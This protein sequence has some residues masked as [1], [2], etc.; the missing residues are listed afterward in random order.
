MLRLVSVI[1]GVFVLG[2]QAESPLD[3]HDF[4]SFQ[5]TRSRAFL[6]QRIT[7]ILQ[8]DPEIA[9]YFEFS[10]SELSIF[11]SPADKASRN[12][13]YQITFGDLPLPE[14]K[15][16]APTTELP[17]LGARIAIDPGHFGGAMAR[18]L[19]ARYIDMKDK[20][21]VEFDEGTLTL[22][23]ALLLE[24]RFKEKGASVLLTRE[25]LEEGGLKESFTKWRSSSA[26]DEAVEAK[27]LG[28]ADP[29]KR[30]AAQKWWKEEATD[31]EVF[32]M[33]YSSLDFVA[34]AEKI[35][36]FDPHLTL[37]IHFNA[38]G[39]REKESGKNIASS[40]NYNMAFVPGS[41]MKGELADPRSRYE[42]V[43]LL[44]TDHLD[45]S[46]EVGGVLMRAALSNTSVS[47]AS[48]METSAPYLR[49][50]CLP[51]CQ[52]GVFARNLGMTRLVRSPIVYGEILCQDNVDECV[53]LNDRSLTVGGLAV[54]ARLGPVVE[55]YYEAGLRY[56]QKR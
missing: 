3:F 50:S 34:R 56:F 13:E 43:R 41:F 27:T 26:F 42:F 37:V 25:H 47:I 16:L 21:G 23:T 11:A 12:P 52:P 17:L 7:Q 53:R 33:L 28:I 1:L 20:P 19:E 6:E 14:R 30:T 45:E 44:V 46:V 2:V 29:A 49:K 31:A 35:N 22:A 40:D 39:G 51:T 15:A 8:K 36:Q 38:A 48:G 5:R 54:P 9:S 24:K 4:D 55:S 18:T 32:S 10:D